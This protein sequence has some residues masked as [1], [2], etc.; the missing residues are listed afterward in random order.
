MIKTYRTEVCVVNSNYMNNRIET[1]VM[2]K[3]LSVSSPIYSLLKGCHI[4]SDRREPDVFEM[5]SRRLL[6]VVGRGTGGR[7]PRNT[8]PFQ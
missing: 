4:Q 5:A 8:M 1:A 2:F 6:C 7:W 3:N